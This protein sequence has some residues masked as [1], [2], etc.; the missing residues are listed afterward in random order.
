M[1]QV[2]FFFFEN[3]TEPCYTTKAALA[4]MHFKN[5]FVHW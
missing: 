1:K 3:F 2:L 4:L 5:W